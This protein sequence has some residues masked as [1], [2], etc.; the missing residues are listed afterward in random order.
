MLL[1]DRLLH[2]FACYRHEVGVWILPMHPLHA[3]RAKVVYDNVAL[4]LGHLAELGHLGVAVWA[5]HRV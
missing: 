1:F 5:E 3:G 2:P 4:V